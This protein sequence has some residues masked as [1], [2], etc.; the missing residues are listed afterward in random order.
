MQFFLNFS[1]RKEV[2]MD[3]E[4]SKKIIADHER[5]KDFFDNYLIPKLPDW[6]NDRSFPR[7]FF[8][9]LGKKG[10]F[11]FRLK[12]SQLLR[13]PVLRQA[14]LAE[15]LAILSPGVAIAMIV[16]GSLGLL[17]LALFG[18]KKLQ[19]KHA[20]EALKGKTL[21][22]LGN[23]ESHAGSDVASISMRAKKSND[24]WILNGAKA[25][26][27]NG[28]ESDLAII[29]AITDPR[30]SRNRRISMFL[31]DLRASDILRKNLNKQLW[32]PSELAR[33]QFND[34]FVPKDHLMG[35]PG[36]GL[37]QVLSIFTH[38]RIPISALTLGTAVGAFNMGL[39]HAR[40]RKV[41]G[42]KI[43]DFQAKS[44]EIS[45][46]YARIE[47]TRMMIW[48]ACWRMEKNRDSHLESSMAKYLSVQ[49]AREVTAWAADIFG[50]ASVIYEHPI[51]KFPLDAWAASLGEG[52]QDVQKLIIFREF[53]KRH[54]N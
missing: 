32:I 24:G 47:A 46:Y 29:T 15:Q 25:Y 2:I 19:N 27:T 41:L 8:H 16:Q 54:E 7:Q 53:M 44:F 3:F 48:Q 50:A 42:S 5:F 18:S 36:R 11:G 10:W 38:S 12:D 17:G 21:I 1:I 20:A 13:K 6:Y 43:I 52:T 34:V 45:D 14:I 31:V 37:Q 35:K 40:K 39:Q 28:M 4:P 9:M 26:V 51:H 49:I 22:C 30:A 33:I 23:T